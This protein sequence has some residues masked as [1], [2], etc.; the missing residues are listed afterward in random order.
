MNEKP[1]ENCYWVVPGLLLAGEYPR[2]HD[3]ETSPAKLAALTEWGVDAFIDLTEEDELKPYAQWLDP[4][5]HIHQR[6][7][8]R[9]AHTP[10]SREL[11]AAALDAIDEHIADGRPA[12]VHC[13]GG[14]GRTGTII[15]CWLARHGEPGPDALGRLAELWQDCPKS[16]WIRS[17]ENT[18]QCLYVTNW[19]EDAG[20]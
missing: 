4:E 19:R 9:D 8:I 3:E 11:T 10:A 20:K 2:N 6:F 12:Y 5:K 13:H 15:G 14:I 7:P 17:P 18:A 16:A 1:M